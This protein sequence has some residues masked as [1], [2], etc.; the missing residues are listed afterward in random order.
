MCIN[1]KAVL[2]IDHLQTWQMIFFR[3]ITFGLKY[4]IFH[5]IKM[6]ERWNANFTGSTFNKNVKNQCE[7]ASQNALKCMSSLGSIDSSEERKKQNNNYIISEK[8]N[9]SILISCL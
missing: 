4:E 1:T 7:Q 8:G 3:N 5:W 9:F 2:A 6:K